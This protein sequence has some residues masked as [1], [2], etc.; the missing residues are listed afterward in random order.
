MKDSKRIPG[1][2]SPSKSIDTEYQT[3]RCIRDPEY[4]AHVAVAVGVVLVAA[5]GAAEAAAA[6]VTIAIAIATAIATMTLRK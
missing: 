4:V 5:A 2:A 3:A 6:V 1:R